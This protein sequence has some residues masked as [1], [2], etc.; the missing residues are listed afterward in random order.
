MRLLQSC[1]LAGLH[2]LA[3]LLEHLGVCLQSLVVN[4][5][6]LWNQS[7]CSLQTIWLGLFGAF[8]GIFRLSFGVD[9][10]ASSEVSFEAILGCILGY[11]SGDSF[12]WLRMEFNGP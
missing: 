2:G 3:I 8:K 5:H 11:V 10:G 4:P 7:V 12:Y 6:M 1:L 9:F